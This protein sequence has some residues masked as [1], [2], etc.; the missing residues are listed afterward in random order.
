VWQDRERRLLLVLLV[1]LVVLVVRMP[2]TMM[3]VVWRHGGVSGEERVSEPWGG[4]L[5]A[6]HR[7]MLICASA[8]M[9]PERRERDVTLTAE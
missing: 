5:Y 8:N 9:V 1:V 6:H 4:S 7:L 2:M 3:A